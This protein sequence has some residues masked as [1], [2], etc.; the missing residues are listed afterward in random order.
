MARPD[1]WF[2]NVFILPGL[3][4]AAVFTKTPWRDLVSP[5]V[6]G[7]ISACLIASANYVINE[8]V[9]ADDDRFHPVKRDR[10]AVRKQVRMPWVWVEY[11]LLILAG[12]GLAA[13]VSV[14]F[15][16]ASVLFAVAGI[17]YNMKPFRTKDRT[18]LDVVSESV[19]NP[20]RLLLGWFMVTESILPP[21]SLVLGYWMGGAFLMGVKRYSELRYLGGSGHAEQY[22]RSF[23]HYTEENLLTSSFFYGLFS[24]FCL[25]VFLVKH[26]VELLISVPFL[27]VLFAWYLRIGLKPDSSAQHPEKLYREGFF[28]AYCVI[29]AALL[30]VLFVWDVPLLHWFLGGSQYRG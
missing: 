11:A 10:P 24:A 28:F 22:R 26:R 30:V 2:K 19:N 21:A 20:I 3:L 5:L 9:D 1:H 15:L 14:G 6:V 7:G 18:Y 23:R 12:M 13:T 8:W 27:A 25:G 4:T 29:L 17:V 16:A